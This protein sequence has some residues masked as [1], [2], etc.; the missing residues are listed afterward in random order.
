MPE[1]WTHTHV[2]VTGQL[3]QIEAVPRTMPDRAPSLAETYTRSRATAL[4]N[5]PVPHCHRQE[6]QRQTT[7]DMYN[8]AK[9]AHV[10]YLVSAGEK[11]LFSI[12]QKNGTLWSQQPDQVLGDL[13]RNLGLVRGTCTDPGGSVGLTR[14][15]LGQTRHESQVVVFRLES[16]PRVLEA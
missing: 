7:F 1:R 15:A 2:T 6:R 16:L 11:G 3:W 8:L 13:F 10:L 12:L 5:P 4:V 9:L 14:G